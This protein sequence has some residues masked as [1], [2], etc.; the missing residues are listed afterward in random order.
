MERFLQERLQEAVERGCR[1]MR[2]YVGVDQF[3][4]R[5]AGG[6][7]LL[8]NPAVEINLR[9]TMGHV[10]RNIYDL[11]FRELGLGEG[12]HCFEPLQGVV[13]ADG[14]ALYKRIL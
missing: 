5:R 11:H 6:G 7:E 10:A 14:D 9:M 2:G 1:I 3:I 4:C 8:Y 13:P 12:T